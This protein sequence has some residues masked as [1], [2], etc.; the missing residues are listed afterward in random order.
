MGLLIRNRTFP[1]IFIKVYKWRCYF[2]RKYYWKLARDS[3]L[4]SAT[5]TAR[6]NTPIEAKFSKQLDVET[7]NTKNFS[8]RNDAVGDYVKDA[9]VTFFLVVQMNQGYL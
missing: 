6:P 5:N 1:N 9:L 4:L 3:I 7:V 8:Q 2:D